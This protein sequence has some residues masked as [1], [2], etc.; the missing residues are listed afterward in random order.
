MFVSLQFKLELRK[1][2]REK[3]IKLMRKQSSAIR[4][5]YNMLK[6]LEKEKAKNPH[7][8]IYQR[9]RQ[10]FPELPTKY[11]DSAI[12]K[13]KQYPTDRPVVFGGKRLFEKL[14]KNHLSGK[15][16]EKLKKQWRE[17][18][19]G[20]LISIGSKADKGNRLMRFEDL[21]GQL[22]LRI[23]TGNREFVYAKVLREPSN[24]K[25]KWL[26][27]MAML[28]E[29]WQTKNYF[30]YT[31]ELKL[32]DGEV[33]GSVSF[34]LPTPEVKYTKEN[35]VIAID[36]NAS[37]IHLAIA[38]VSKTGELLSYKTI[39]LHHL[40]GLSQN[41]KDHQEWILAHQIVDLAI[42][43]G[44][45][46]A[47]E[48]L[49]KLKKGVRRDGK[50]TLRKRLHQ[51]NVKKFLQ[52]LKRVALLKGVEV[53]EV[54]PAYT[55]VIGMLKYAPQL[56]IDKDIAGAYVIGR[57]ALGFK[58]DV[59]ENYERL[60]KNKA[61]LEFAL[62]RYE[63]REKELRELIEK[64]SNEY[65]RNALESELKVVENSKKLLVNLIQSLQ[66]ES[67]GCEGANGSNPEQ[68]RVAKTTL[69]SVWQVLRVALLFPI[70]GRVLPRDLSPL[71]PVL[72]EGVWGRVRSR[73]VP[74]EAGG[75]V[76]IRDF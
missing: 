50:A 9:L 16:R 22:C 36:T 67:S 62:K 14:C 74:F 18:R 48:N 1:E 33:Y 10:L 37:P 29:S 24:S 12:Y 6:E 56:S 34:E 30:A 32:R 55:S 51:W 7:A 52:K 75:T 26:T 20:T 57:R 19:Q 59:P 40:L 43:K 47:V 53:I 17:L 63:E 42:Q 64:E 41:S 58:E 3:L 25:D 66:S 69:Q 39:S 4:V 2:D 31:V 60:L 70:L 61:Y 21:N 5:A 71:K 44:K 23:T 28:L 72:V 46:I 76:P 49:K 45:A 65:K 35:G 15:A 73:L 13:A 11:I 54:N 38:G 8:Q 27:F 68:G